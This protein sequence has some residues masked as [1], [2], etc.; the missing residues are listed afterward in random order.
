MIYGTAKGWADVLRTFPNGTLHPYGQLASD[1][2]EGLFPVR[3]DIRLPMAN[4]PPPARHS[5]YIKAHETAK[6]KRFYGR[7][8]LAYVLVLVMHREYSFDG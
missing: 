5:E 3:N 6:V 8:T 7:L 2:D 4:P 1:K